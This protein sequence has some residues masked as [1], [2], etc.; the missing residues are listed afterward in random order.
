LLKFSSWFF[1]GKQV[2]ASEKTG[3]L[4]LDFKYLVWE[5]GAGIRRRDQN[6][7]TLSKQAKI[8]TE[9]TYSA[10]PMAGPN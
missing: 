5:K 2:L 9:K 3:G 6:F 8:R 4:F 10:D 1:K 7:S